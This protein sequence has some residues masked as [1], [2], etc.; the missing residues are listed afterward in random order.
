MERKNQK[1]KFQELIKTME[2][3]QETEKGKLKGG[4]TVLSSLSS[5]LDKNSGTCHNYGDCTNQDNTGDCHNHPDKPTI[6][7]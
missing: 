4:I 2:T 7:G 6:G 1:Q 3:L 5:S